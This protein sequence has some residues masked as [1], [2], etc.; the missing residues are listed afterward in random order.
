MVAGHEVLVRGSILTVPEVELAAQEQLQPAG[1]PLSLHSDP[2]LDTFDTSTAP[3]ADSH[4]REIAGPSDHPAAGRRQ[5]S[6]VHQ[7]HLRQ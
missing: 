2:H 4:E 1:L 6:N 5:L 3:R 7:S